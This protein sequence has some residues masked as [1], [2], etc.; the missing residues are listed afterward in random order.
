M[1]KQVF[2]PSALLLPAETSGREQLTSGQKVESPPLLYSCSHHARRTL[3]HCF[4]CL[5]SPNVVNNPW[6]IGWW[7]E[8]SCQNNLCWALA[9]LIPRCSNS[10]VEFCTGAWPTGNFKIKLELES[11]LLAGMITNTLFVHK[12]KKIYIRSFKWLLC[13]LDCANT[14]SSFI[15]FPG[16]SF[17]IL[18][19]RKMFF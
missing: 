11:S 18:V 19:I 7:G 12:N 6:I 8:N 9:S 1:F 14:G 2:V 16:R 5:S 17:R 4:C 15:F 10:L 3:F 13:I